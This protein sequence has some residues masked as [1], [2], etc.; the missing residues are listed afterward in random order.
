M[1]F[2][3]IHAFIGLNTF[4]Q[5]WNNLADIVI[6]KFVCISISFLNFHQTYLII[7]IA[8]QTFLFYEIIFGAFIFK[9]ALTIF[10][11]NST[12]FIVFT[13][14][15]INPFSKIIDKFWSWA[16][17][18]SCTVNKFYFIRY[19]FCNFFYIFVFLF[20]NWSSISKVL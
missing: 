1:K 7:L 10:V 11:L 5:S 3:S 17:H 16:C 2:F 8:T 9:T 4:W 14:N 20:F 13:F 15:F 6:R 12:G 19:G 18:K